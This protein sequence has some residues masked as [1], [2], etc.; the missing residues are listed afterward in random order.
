MKKFNNIVYVLNNDTNALSPSFV[1]A[2]NLAKVN[3]ANLTLLYIHPDIK[4][5]GLVHLTGIT[6]EEIKG[7]VL[8]KEHNRLNAF[9]QSIDQSLNTTAEV[10]FGKKYIETIR[11]VYDKQFDLV[12][13]EVTN[14][15][16]LDRLLGSDDMHLLRKC[17][18]PVWLI[19]KDEK[20][21]HKN[22][23]A[24]VDFDNE[25]EFGPQEIKYELNKKIL[26]LSSLI[27]L[28]E[29]ATLHVVNVYDVPHAGFIG[30]WVEQP[31]KVEKQLFESEYRNRRYQM[32]TM[33]DSLKQMLGEETFRYLSPQPHV[34]QGTPDRELPKLANNIN[35][36]L[37]VMGTVARSGIAGVIIGNTAETILAQLQ[38]SVL[39]LKPDGFVSPISL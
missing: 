35:A 37:M 17:P 8:E 29:M 24:A 22:I 10:R 6:E 14:L 16:W 9:I 19:K 13:K 34:V 23:I 28:S 7:K 33:M 1:Q 32:N 5:T 2:I 27:A 26:E 25:F 21:K 18:C 15:D 20:P 39:T 12:V 36:D 11:A 31:E 3:Q 38:C 4:S 30:L